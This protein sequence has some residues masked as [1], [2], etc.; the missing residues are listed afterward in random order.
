MVLTSN[1]DIQPCTHIT[2]YSAW[3]NGNADIKHLVKFG[4]PAWMH[5][6]GASKSAGKP[7]SKLDPRAKKVHIVGY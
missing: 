1:P 5:L 2:P 4:S 7:T 6:Y 3:T